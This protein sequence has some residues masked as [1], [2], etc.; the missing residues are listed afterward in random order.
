MIKET[1]LTTTLL[2]KAL[3]GE[4]HLPEDRLYVPRVDTGYTQYNTPSLYK[5][6][7]FV[8]TFDDGPHITNTPK[9]LDILKKYNVKATFFIL[10]ENLNKTTLPIFKRMLDEGH[11]PSSHDHSH[12]HNNRV[13]EKTFR[14]KITQSMLKLKEFYA[15]AGHEMKTFYFRFPYAE[16]GGNANYHHMNVIREVSEKLFGKN[17]IHFVF[18]DIDSGDWIPGLTGS[19]VFKNIKAYQEGG[20]YITY[21]LSRDNSGRQVILKKPTKVKTPLGGGV[22]LQHDIQSRTLEGTDKFLKYAQDNYI[23]IV[24]L[25]SVEEFS[26]KGLDCKFR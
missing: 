18:W 7:K 12:D 4:Y 26:Y 10:T 3:L 1:I 5:T 8:L 2:M 22:I 24:P 15:L 11:I 14:E 20:D 19:E 25:T 13:D 21:R 6:N 23:D 9:L 17:C 16:Y